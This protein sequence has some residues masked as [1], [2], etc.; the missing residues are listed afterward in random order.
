[1]MKLLGIASA[2]FL[3]GLSAVIAVAGTNGTQLLGIGP[4]SRSMGGTGIAYPMDAISAVFGNPAAMCFGLYCPESQVDFSVSLLSPD[5]KASVSG[6]GVGGTIRAEGD[7]NTF[8]VPAIGLSIPI[9]KSMPLWR[10]GLSAYGVSGLGGDYRG[11][12]LDQPDFYG[13]GVPLV[14]GEY[15]NLQTTKFAPAVAFQPSDCLS[16]GLAIHLDYESFDLRHGASY[17]FGWGAQAGVLYKPIDSVSL[18]LTYI[19]PQKV[20]HENVADLDT[21]GRLDDLEIESPQQ[22]GFGAAYHLQRDML[23]VEGDIR[24][25]NWSDSKG[26]EDI[27]FEDQWVFAL[28]L[29]YK[30]TAKLALRA[31][32][33]Y[34]NSPVDD[35][36]G[37]IGTGVSAIQGHPLPTYYLETFRTMGFATI[38]EQQLTFGIG[39]A[40]S[41]SITLNLGYEH[42]FEN[43]V[44]STG[45]DLTG[46]PVTLKSEVSGNTFDL[47]LIFRF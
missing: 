47:G 16:V 34:G 20:E 36:H 4:V 17:D 15:T 29:Q 9:S 12:E 24:W 8:V 43:T 44:E 18:G 14:T 19:S 1:M 32:Y 6:P 33:N 5:T 40:F 13:P 11:T 45:T 21:D 30:P 3:L 37:F 23:V 38:L 46:Q 7:D 10:F 41:P 42:S 27:G 35:H 31:G 25:L 22:V 26:Y 39:Y 2:F 28:G